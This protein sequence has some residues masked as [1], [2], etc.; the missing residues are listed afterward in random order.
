MSAFAVAALNGQTAKWQFGP[1]GAHTTFV[2]TSTSARP[3]ATAAPAC[4]VPH[5]DPLAATRLG[6][7]QMA[8]ALQ[9]L[10]SQDYRPRDN[11]TTF[12]AGHLAYITFELATAAPGT[13]GVTFCTP[14]GNTVG[15]LQVPAGSTGRYGEFSASVDSADLGQGTATLTWNGAVAAAV[16]F[17]VTP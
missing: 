3:S 4:I 1:F 12:H 5:V 7:V 6:H 9:D 17:S 13:V 2:P 11:V 15:T 8:T 10:G 14:G 16:R